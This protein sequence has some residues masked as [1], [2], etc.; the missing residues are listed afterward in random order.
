M[1]A[2]VDRW[3]TE[4]IRPPRRLGGRVLVLCRTRASLSLVRRWLAARGGAHGIDVAT[5]ETLAA[6]V[7]RPRVLDPDPGP[8]RPDDVSLPEGT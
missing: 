5:P 3:L 7:W 6:Q 8:E 2:E 4:R 1:W